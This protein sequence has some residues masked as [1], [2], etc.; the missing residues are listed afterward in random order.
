MNKTNTGTV[1]DSAKLQAAGFRSKSTKKKVV[2][3][4]TA[5]YDTAEGCAVLYALRS[6]NTVFARAGIRDSEWLELPCIPD[7]Q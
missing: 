5:V 7:T 2:M 4:I 6:D 3:A 1:D